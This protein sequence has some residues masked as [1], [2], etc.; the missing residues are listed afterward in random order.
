MIEP[1]P[2]LDNTALFEQLW[3]IT[4]EL[5]QKLEA[6]FE[7]HPDPSTKDLQTYST[8]TGDA[9]GSLNTFSGPEIDRLVHS[10]IRNPKLGFSHIRLIIWL[11]PHIRVPHLACAFAT[12]PH[13]FFYMDYIPR[14]DLFTD[15]EYLDRY[16][17]PVNQTYLT[18]LED[19][20]FEPHIS[21]NV[22]M[23]QAESPASLCYTSK[24]SN[25]TFPLVRTTAHEMMDRWLLWIDEAE[26]VTQNERAALSERDLI[27]L[28]TVIERDPDNKIAVGLL[29]EELSNK[30]VRSLWGGDG[31][32]R[33]LSPSDTLRERDRI[34]E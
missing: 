5:R 20:R 27:V 29:G 31:A 8:I 16:Y 21:K 17:E 19:S 10:W 2:D 26:S 33:P 13:L 9:Q 34:T 22:Y 1:Q 18:L 23:R 4:N 7:L 15:L 6:R 12:I 11:G 32:E 28:R 24:L 3:G 14:S 30:L 25:E